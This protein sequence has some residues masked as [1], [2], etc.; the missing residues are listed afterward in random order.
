MTDLYVAL[1]L[2]ALLIFAALKK[3]ALTVPAVLLA[4]A[5]LTCISLCTGWKSALY[6]AVAYAILVAVD[7]AV[8]ER[9]EK[10]V[11]GVHKKGS[12][13]N[14]SQVLANGAFAVIASVLYAILHNK[15]YM[16]VYLICVA[17][18]CADSIASDVGVLS[19]KKPVSIVTFR[20]VDTGIS[21]GVSAL[22][23]LSSLVMCLSLALIGT[24]CVGFNL[25][26]LL[27]LT[28]VPYLGMIA[29]SVA[30][31]LFQAKYRCAVCGKNTELH[32][33]CGQKTIRTGGVG[34]ITNSVVN[35]ITNLLCGTAAYFT[36][37]LFLK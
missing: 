9:A 10:K 19:R 18:S 2:S 17:E 33:H 29:D 3:E 30:G 26:N 4:A 27:I 24:V 5:L 34:I 36:V 11:E 13:R 25:Q 22:G 35:A 28:L 31:A 1:A 20:E 14:V 37:L 23:M 21:G 32:T 16:Y 8:K 7:S 15:A 6:L 12:A